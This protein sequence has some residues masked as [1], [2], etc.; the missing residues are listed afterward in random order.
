MAIRMRSWPRCWR[1]DR[2]SLPRHLGVDSRD[3][4]GVENCWEDACAGS[5]QLF[6]L[7]QP[8]CGPAQARPAGSAGHGGVVRRHHHWL[9]PGL[10]V[11]W[12]LV[13]AAVVAGRAFIAY[14]MLARLSS[15]SLP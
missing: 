10:M 7:W 14:S 13:L 12:V 3:L 1:S 11:A 9:S 8:V 2:F 4:P 6:L 15:I 5:V